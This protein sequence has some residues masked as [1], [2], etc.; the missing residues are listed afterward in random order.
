MPVPSGDRLVELAKRRPV[1]LRAAGFALLLAALFADPLWT[2]RTFADRDLVPFFFPIE[3]AVHESWARLRIPLWAP[4]ISF[5]RPLAANPNTG[6]FYPVRIAMAALPFLFSF[7]LFPVLHLWL[8]AMGMFA[9]ARFLGSSPAAAALGAIVYS[10]SGPALA[11]IAYPDFLPGFALLPMVVWAAGRLGRAGRR[12]DAA[13]FG[14][15]WGVDLLAG[16]VFTA[17]LALA[18]SLLLLWEESAAAERPRRLS[19]LAAA[20]AA[21]T[22]LAGVQI[23]PALLLMPETA[24]ALGRFPLRYSLTWSVSP[25]RLA[26]LAVPFP[27]GNRGAGDRVWGEALWS[28]KSAGFFNTLYAGSF[29]A[30]AL[31]VRGNRGRRFPRLLAAISLAAATFGSLLPRA[32]L[33]RPSPI[34]L[35][36]PEKLMVGFLAALALWAA[37][38]FDGLRGNGGRRIAL[39][40]AGVGLLLLSAAGAV[41]AGPAATARFVDGHWST[42][43]HG[44]ALAAQRL[45]GILAGSAGR[46]LLLSGFLFL[47]TKRRPRLAALVFLFVLAD[48]D[49]VRRSFLFP[50]S[51]QVLFPAPLARAIRRRDPG[52]AFALVPL[53]DYYISPPS[54]TLVPDVD[55]PRVFLSSDL[56]AAFGVPYAFNDDYDASDLY[57]VDLARREIFRGGGRS[58][59][60][61]SYLSAFSARWTAVEAGRRPDGFSRVAARA[62]PAWLLENTEA[63]PRMRFATTVADVPGPR[64]AY[65]L[66]HGQQ[67]DL[68]RVTVL[69]TGSSAQREFSPG[70]LRV[71]RREPGDLLL[72]TE[73]GGEARLLLARAWF[74]YRKILVDGAPAAAWP[75]NLCW[76]AL[77]VP[78]GIHT[79]HVSEELPGGSAGPLLTLAG[80]F[81]IILLAAGR[82]SR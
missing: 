41:A 44:G 70:R 16:D 78:A 10:L 32:W 28:G 34:P 46:W 62:G 19:L 72:R 64:A 49:T 21:G 82:R 3:K 63:L 43:V 9:L 31:L 36:Y 54:K 15:L 7:K 45:P 13:L 42:I 51:E 4:E 59:S 77:A 50:D 22:L 71:V 74:P 56:A 79:I 57:R 33:D 73:T 65:G 67:I 48:L 23:V 58:P 26:E 60:L 69:E 76:T 47:W 52:R 39:L 11:E 80:A 66:I 14:L 12:R 6:V 81:C 8:A 25:W 29:A 20:T 68:S 37:D 1:L 75:A 5:G 40:P 24:R 55:L 17:G 35:R 38:L 61:P 27:F 30:L 53:H 2:R 18:G